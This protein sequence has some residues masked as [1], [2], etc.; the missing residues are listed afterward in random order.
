MEGLGGWVGG[1]APIPKQAGGRT[2]RVLIVI[3]TADQ[4]EG[5]AARSGQQRLEQLDDRE[6]I[7]PSPA[8]GSQTSHKT[9]PRESPVIQYIESVFPVTDRHLPL[10]IQGQALVVVEE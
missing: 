5:G 8:H 9:G 1:D 4:L 3:E 7:N 6:K 10:L 2:V